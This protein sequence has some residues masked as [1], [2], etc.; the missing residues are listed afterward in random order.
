MYIF[1]IT[2]KK[3]HL[4]FPFN[5]VKSQQ[6]AKTTLTVCTHNLAMDSG[7]FQ[8]KHFEKKNVQGNITYEKMQHLAL[9]HLK[10]KN[11]DSNLEK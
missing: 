3:Y 9:S 8:K 2:K 5:L 1:D 6:C 11:V 7:L 10:I 4:I